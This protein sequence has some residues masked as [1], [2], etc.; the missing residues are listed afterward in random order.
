[1][2]G[3]PNMGAGFLKMR[4]LFSSIPSIPSDSSQN[5]SVDL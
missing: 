2:P 4:Q 3:E 5:K 1:M